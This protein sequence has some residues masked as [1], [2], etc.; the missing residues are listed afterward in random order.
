MPPL[1]ALAAASLTLF[2]KTG[3]WNVFIQ[4]IEMLRAETRIDAG[5]FE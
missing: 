2:D 1:S 3:P 4:G 5:R